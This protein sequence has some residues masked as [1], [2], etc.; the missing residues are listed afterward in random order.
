MR[1]RRVIALLIACGMTQIATAEPPRESQRLTW[2]DAQHAA[3]VDIEVVVDGDSPSQRW[4]AALGKLFDFFDRDGDD[5]LSAEEVSRLPSAFA[6]RQVL[7]GDFALQ[8]GGAPRFAEIDGDRDD[9]I[10]R[11]ELTDY[12]RRHGV[13]NLLVASTRVDGAVE[14]HA[15][16]LRALDRSSD[17]NLDAAELAEAADLLQTHDR[18]DDELVGPGEL[19]E[20]IDRYPGAVAST[21]V[22]RNV[23]DTQV[24]EGFTLDDAA[25]PA[26]D[27]VTL[28]LSPSEPAA[29]AST[30]WVSRRRDDVQWH[31]RTDRGLLQSQTDAA[32]QDARAWLDRIDTNRDGMLVEA[33]ATG[34]DRPRFEAWLAFAD[35]DH[36]HR[37]PRAESNA[38]LK[39]QQAVADAQVMLTLLDFGRG[40]FEYVDVNHDGGLS[41]TELRDLPR[42]LDQDGCLVEG[43][44]DVARLPTCILCVAAQG[45]PQSVLLPREA[46]GP[47]WFQGMD[48][49]GDGSVSP[50]EFLG[51]RRRFDQFDADRDGLLTTAEAT[52]FV[53]SDP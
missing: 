52:A 17:G 50:A 20:R 29:A 11:D 41:R 37:L 12:Y 48:R 8:A 26:I 13:G 35:R 38:W 9:A 32:M 6:L 47:A 5:A 3:H 19:S 49:N 28:E 7:W 16:L 18:N 36:D 24:K 31:F 40:L 53:R 45:H 34:P 23:E 43:R 25:P 1:L 51:A 42:R 14:L 33:E 2:R 4:N 27:G 15:A 10:A 39:L 44:L 30:S 21:L 46:G 22:R